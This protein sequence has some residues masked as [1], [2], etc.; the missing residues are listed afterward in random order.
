MPHVLF[1]GVGGRVQGGSAFIRICPVLLKNTDLELHL[2]LEAMACVVPS[3]APGL[4]W[5][6]P[7]PFKKFPIDFKIVQWK[8]HLEN[9]LALSILGLIIAL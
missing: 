9:G 3:V 2:V 8:C 6:V 4:S 1:L 7:P 5:P